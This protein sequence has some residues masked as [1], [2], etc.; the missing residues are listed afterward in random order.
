[1][2]ADAGED[3]EKENTPPLLVGLQACKTKHFKANFL[4]VPGFWLRGTLSDKLDEPEEIY[5]PSFKQ[6]GDTQWA[7]DSFWVINSS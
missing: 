3:V 1:V 6:L 2:T 7:I 4:L 5:R